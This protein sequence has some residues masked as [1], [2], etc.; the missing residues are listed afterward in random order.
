MAA[1]PPRAVDSGSNRND[2]SFDEY[3]LYHRKAPRV[4]SVPAKFTTTPTQSTDS[5]PNSP[6]GHN[7]KHDLG[8]SGTNHVDNSDHEENDFPRATSSRAK[9]PRHISTPQHGMSESEDL[10]EVSE[11]SSE[12]WNKDSSTVDLI[13]EN[14]NVSNI[15]GEQ[16]SPMLSQIS[17]KIIFIF[18]TTKLDKTCKRTQYSFGVTEIVI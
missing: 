7:L 9:G 10:E 6:Q 2:S 16:L 15:T 3:K 1:S 12:K 11:A 13:I 18:L 14:Q 8:K 17:R 4:V 5:I